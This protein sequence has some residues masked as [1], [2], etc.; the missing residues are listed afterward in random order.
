MT[1]KV[2]DK[3]GLEF[4]LTDEIWHH[5]QESHP[6]IDSMEIVSTVLYDPDHIVRS[7][8]ESTSCLYYKREGKYY[9]VVVVNSEQKKIKTAYTTNTIKSGES[10]WIK[11]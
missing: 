5:I 3:G 6:E 8:W 4:E 9:K 2:I 7:N 11:N 10:V 1:Q